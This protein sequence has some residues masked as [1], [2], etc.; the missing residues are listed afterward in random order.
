MFSDRKA[1]LVIEKSGHRGR[2]EPVSW[3]ISPA[4][5]A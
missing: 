1:E 5:E 2:L 3:L 4:D